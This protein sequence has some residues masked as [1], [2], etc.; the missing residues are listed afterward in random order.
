MTGH[1]HVRLQR[2]SATTGLW[3][4]WLQGAA[5]CFQGILLEGF[6]PRI[7]AAYFGDEFVYPAGVISVVRGAAGWHTTWVE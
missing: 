4:W 5:G 7:M 1:H 6:V 3:W 2:V